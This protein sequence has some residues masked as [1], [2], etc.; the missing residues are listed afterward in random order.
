MKKEEFD[1]RVKDFAG[2]KEDKFKLEQTNE[3]ILMIDKLRMD[4]V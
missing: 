1:E 3:L 4:M 2:T